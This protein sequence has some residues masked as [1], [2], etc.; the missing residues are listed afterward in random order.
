MLIY[1]KKLIPKFQTNELQCSDG[2][3][4]GTCKA[5]PTTTTAQTT[6]TSSA[7]FV[8]FSALFFLIAQFF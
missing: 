3:N 4:D 1:S 7:Q 2:T 5:A 8:S 6:T